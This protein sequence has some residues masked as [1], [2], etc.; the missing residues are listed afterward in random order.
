MID[1]YLLGHFMFLR[2]KGFPHIGDSTEIQSIQFNIYVFHFSVH[3][4]F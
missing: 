1:F 2:N 4:W 3:L